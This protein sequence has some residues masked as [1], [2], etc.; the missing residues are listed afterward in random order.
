MWVTENVEIDDA[1]VEALRDGK[2]VI[3]AG[4]G[5]SMGAPTSLPAFEGLAEELGAVAKIERHPHELVESYL[6][7]VADSG[8]P[9]H[10]QTAALISKA[11][12]SNALHR[13]LI[14]LAQVGG[15]L[16]IVTTNFD[17]HLS[18]CASERFGAGAIPEY[19]APALPLGDDFEGIVY[20]HGAVGRNPRR[21]VLTDKDFSRAYITRGWARQFLL[22]LFGSW[23]VLFVGFSHND[24]ILT[25]LARG[26]P[27]GT[28]RYAL[29]QEADQPRFQMLDINALVFP[30]ETG[31]EKY[32]PL[33]DAIEAWTRLAGMGLIEHEERVRDLTASGPP[34]TQPD[35]DYARSVINNPERVSFFRR[36]ARSLEWLAWASAEPVFQ[37]L[38]EP[39]RRED[40]SDD[41]VSWFSEKYVIDEPAAALGIL[42][43]RRGQMSPRLWHGIAH[44]LWT[45]KA[46]A[47]VRAQWM[48]HLLASAPPDTADYL[49]YLLVHSSAEEFAVPLL[50][51]EYLTEPEVVLES[52]M[53]SDSLI[54]S[55]RPS[56]KIRGDLH[57]LYD[58]WQKV[59]EPRLES[60]AMPLLEICT[61]HFGRTA[62][63]ARS[64]DL[65]GSGYDP[66]SRLRPSLLAQ[67]E[68]V[69]YRRWSDLLVDVARECLVWLTEHDKEAARRTIDTW[70]TSDAPL[71]RRLGVLGLEKASWVPPSEAV[72]VLVDLEFVLDPVVGG[73]VRSLIRNR[74]GDLD[75]E[76][77]D[78]LLEAVDAGPKEV[79][80]SLRVD[81][82]RQR[83]LFAMR[84]AG[85]NDEGV[86]ERLR[87]IET[88]HPELATPDEPEVPV[89]SITEWAGPGSPKSVDEFL[90]Y[91]PTD[92]EL[93]DFLLAYNE[94]GWDR[95]REGL[96][97][98]LQVAA[99]RNF[100]WSLALAQAVA[101]RNEWGTDVF[102]R[103]VGA[104][105]EQS[106]SVDQWR[107]LFDLLDLDPAIDQ[108]SYE[109][110][111]LLDRGLRDGEGGLPFALLDRGEA[112]AQATWEA[113]RGGDTEDPV[114][115]DWLGRAINRPAGKLSLFFVRA[116]SERKSAEALSH[117]SEPAKSVFDQA[118]TQ[119]TDTDRL[120]SVVLASQAHFLYS[121]DTEWARTALLSVFDW[122]SDAGVAERSWDGFL[123]WGRLPPPLIQELMPLYIR[124]A[125]HLDQLDR[126]R[127]R[128]HEHLAHIALREHQPSGDRS[129][130]DEFITAAEPTDVAGFTRAIT[131]ALRDLPAEFKARSWDEW[132]GAYWTRRI[133]NLPRPMSDEEAREIVGWA[134]A[135]GDRA[136]DAIA[137]AISGPSGGAYDLFFHDLEKTGLATEHPALLGTL[138]L[139][140]LR[141]Q[142]QPFYQC[143]NAV[144]LFGQLRDTNTIDDATANSI[145][146]ELLRLHCL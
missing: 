41:L 82:A 34:Q 2:L 116:L 38:F 63:L 25:Y 79:V 4:A 21:L 134:V 50:L 102:G 52:D 139:H 98:V 110:S 106:L 72:R 83:V 9:L 135:I 51:F 145:R 74:G 132:L 73:E 5:V 71:L 124:A 62:M 39:G 125:P 113:T 126:M 86:E 45:G 23:S 49:D 105:S 91:E 93:L 130:I 89:V 144:E 97:E 61:N 64:F 3:F 8:F 14:D 115:D 143:S 43:E 33:T 111:D 1:L 137:L 141:K 87:R 146:E 119:E 120:A 69:A 42:H 112:L 114:E 16:R 129:W 46:S 90:E 20:L 99:R 7:R 59:F 26:L 55:A 57:W 122:D 95:N 18:N 127:H 47:E 133:Q 65:G 70:L 121:L 28:K 31:D 11:T 128:F 29:I 10:E 101:E 85:I 44:R 108:H 40:V 30:T 109:V 24:T 94:T 22:D 12:E 75:E 54:P 66:S 88:D 92:P 76:T 84:D 68:E 136:S 35:L 36:Y 81:I 104:W 67:P 118:L 138:L 15:T 107:A 32:Q 13:A 6:G 19:F 131:F 48:P 100:D 103:L 78:H 17:L 53:F 80:E 37:R 96:L 142:R 56:I 117:L 27:P 77:G 60:F 58:S 123:T 140:V